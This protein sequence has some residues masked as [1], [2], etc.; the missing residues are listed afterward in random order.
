MLTTNTPLGKAIYMKRVIAVILI[1]SF[2]V[3][4]A[5]C[6]VQE[7]PVI[8]EPTPIS[9]PTATPT[10]PPTPALTKAP[11]ITETDADGEM[12]ILINQLGYRPND[13][14]IAFIRGS[15]VGAKFMVVNKNNEVVYEGAITESVYD[16]AADETVHHGDFSAFA[17]EGEY[18]VVVE[19]VGSSDSFTISTEPYNALLRDCVLMFT[20]ARCGTEVSG[21][22]AGKAA[23]GACHTAYA[24]GIDENILLNVSGGWHD[25]GD[26]GRYT[27][28]AA[29]AVTDLMLA[30]MQD[31]AKAE[32]LSLADEI[33]YELKWLLK[34]QRSDGGVY[35]KVTTED[36]PGAITPDEDAMQL[37]LSPVST[38]ATADFAAVMA[39]ASTLYNDI[40]AEFAYQMLSAAKKAYEY[41]AVNPFDGGFKN[42]PTVKTGD[43]TDYSDSDERL[44]AAVA[45]YKATGE[46]RYHTDAKK[47]LFQGEVSYTGFGWQDMSAYAHIIYLG[48]D[49]EKSDAAVAEAVKR[50]I[51]KAADKCVA[52]INASGYNIARGTEFTWGSNMF[53]LN[54]AMLLLL[55]SKL[56]ESGVYALNAKYQLD[57]ILGANSLN[58][59]FV[60]GYGSNFPKQPHH[61]PS[62][63]T[64]AAEPG[65]LVGGANAMLDDDAARAALSAAPPAKCYIDDS[66]SYSTNEV[67]IYWNSALVY[68]LS[69]IR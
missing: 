54:D 17:L 44:F 20:R 16:A 24:V 57:Y 36:Y 7:K 13:M 6:A 31:P 40:D 8:A 35:H 42:P 58:M 67:A 19:G 28:P 38:N 52:A 4:L 12:H 61:A 43:Y 63:A 39:L 51:V 60:T 1:L 11:V 14:K 59:C 37:V 25:A 5:S 34:M 15:A 47:L 23:H 65:M 66:E 64:G 49:E 33:A 30:Y 69:A 18:K 22:I 2:I 62:M 46:A 50:G 3:P 27:V 26:Y 21:E 41:L 48:L 68:V 9:A 32:E 53:I 10:A 55:A 45:L 29:K 56:T